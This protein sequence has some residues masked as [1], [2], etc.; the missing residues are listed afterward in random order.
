MIKAQIRSTGTN[1]SMRKRKDEKAKTTKSNT[2]LRLLRSKR[3]ASVEELRRAVGWQSHSV[4]GFLSGTVRRKMGLPL[5]GER[6]KDGLQR[7]RIDANAGAG[8]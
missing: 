2:L 6:G 3:G 5:V 7:Y 1:V 4:R 8:R